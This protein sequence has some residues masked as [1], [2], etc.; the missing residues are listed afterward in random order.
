MHFVD[1]VKF[2]LRI[3]LSQNS[4]AYCR[5]I[6]KKEEDPKVKQ[7]FDKLEKKQRK[8]QRYQ[9]RMDFTGGQKSLD[10]ALEVAAIKIQVIFRGLQ[11]RKR[12]E[13]KRQ[14]LAAAEREMTPRPAG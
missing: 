4:P 13:L 12:V 6:K 8:R 14:E 1:V 2:T 5:E 9:A 11:A 10:I 3:V 7:M